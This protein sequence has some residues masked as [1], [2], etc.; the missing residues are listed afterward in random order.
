MALSE[1]LNFDIEMKLSLGRYNSCNHFNGDFYG[2]KYL[3]VDQV[4]EKKD[5]K[6]LWIGSNDPELIQKV[7]KEILLKDDFKRFQ[8]HSKLIIELDQITRSWFIFLSFLQA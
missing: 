5:G 4:A 7:F 8:R 1:Y 2:H 3:Q 6:Q